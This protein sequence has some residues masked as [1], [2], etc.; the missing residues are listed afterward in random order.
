MNCA[1]W[2]MSDKQSSQD[3]PATKRACEYDESDGN[4]MRARAESRPVKCRDEARD[5]I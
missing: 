1:S 5:I 2:T 4:G 3:V